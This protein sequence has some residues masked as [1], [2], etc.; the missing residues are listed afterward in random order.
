[1]YLWDIDRNERNEDETGKSVRQYILNIF[2]ADSSALFDRSLNIQ[3][4]PIPRNKKI[5]NAQKTSTSLIQV[6]S[7]L[8]IYWNKVM[9]QRT[10]SPS[11]LWLKDSSCP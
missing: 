10:P 9:N 6:Y 5:K 4:F 7:V 8:L 3:W 11:M 2:T 1:M